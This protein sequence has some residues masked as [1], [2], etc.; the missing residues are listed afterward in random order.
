MIRLESFESCGCLEIMVT[1]SVFIFQFS[2]KYIR[3]TQT[4]LNMK[5]Q[6]PG[7]KDDSTDMILYKMLVFFHRATIGYDAST[8]FSFEVMTNFAHL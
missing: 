8:T 1:S 2:K 3:D 7:E 6:G 5:K 4:A